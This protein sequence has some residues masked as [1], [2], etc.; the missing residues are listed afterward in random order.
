M[1]NSLRF[2]VPRA[3]TPMT[4]ARSPIGYGALLFRIAS[5]VSGRVAPSSVSWPVTANVCSPV[6]RAPVAVNVISGCAALSRKSPLFKCRSR[7]SWCVST[8]SVATMT[9]SDDNVPLS[10]SNV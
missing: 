4:S 2:S 10:S 3:E 1:P 9:R 7:A 6:R 5:S 8:L